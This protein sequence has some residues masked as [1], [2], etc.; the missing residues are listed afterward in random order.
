M[1]YTEQYALRIHVLKPQVP[2]ITVGG[3]RAP[4]VK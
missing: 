2:N 4:K 3:D 1:C